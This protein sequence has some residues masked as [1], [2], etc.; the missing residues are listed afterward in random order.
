MIEKNTIRQLEE[1][2]VKVKKSRK[3]KNERKKKKV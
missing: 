3:L 2:D 1:S